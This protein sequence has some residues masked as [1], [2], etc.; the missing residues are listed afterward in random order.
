MINAKKKL[1]NVYFKNTDRNTKETQE[2]L[3]IT[4]NE[5]ENSSYQFI[6]IRNGIIINTQQHLTPYLKP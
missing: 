3:I 4:I 2:N 1:T 6:L 5:Y